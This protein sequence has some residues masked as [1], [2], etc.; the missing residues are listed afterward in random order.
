MM[1]FDVLIYA[2]GIL[3]I[4]IFPSESIF[5]KTSQDLIANNILYVETLLTI[6][7]VDE[8]KCTYLC[9]RYTESKS[10]LRKYTEES[11]TCECL[12]ASEFFADSRKI[13][14]K[15]QSSV[16]LVNRKCFCML[17]KKSYFKI[18]LSERTQVVCPR[19]EH[20]GTRVELF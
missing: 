20:I 2:I 14:K 16:L 11:E 8:F 5:L 7:T 1:S 19:R 6:E 15:M 4:S 9:D 12:F 18:Y 13:S 3:L 17:Y 10:N